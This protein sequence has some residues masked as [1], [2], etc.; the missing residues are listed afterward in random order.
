MVTGELAA[1]GGSLSWA[2]CSIFFTAAVKRLG[3]PALNLV[4]L[5]MAL[6][7]LALA[8][9]LWK[10]DLVPDGATAADGFWLALSAVV[11]LVVGDLFYFASLD[12]VGP[13]IALLLFTL[14]PP[15]AALGELLLFR[16]GL[17]LPGIAGMAVTLSGV[18][19]VVTD[20]KNGTS[21]G[22]PRALL[23]KGVLLGLGA[24][25]CQGAGL[26]LS[27]MGLGTLDGL[28]GTFIR[29]LAAAPLFSLCYLASGRRIGVLKGKGAG[30][31]FALGGAFFGPF[32]GVTLSLVAVKH[33][34]A[35]VAMTLLSTT[36]VTV[37]PYVVFLYGERI[38]ARAVAGA[39]I[40]VAG[41]ALLCL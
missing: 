32:L 11:G 8:L 36:P 9:L 40:A 20:R 21:S 39:L 33:T 41:V 29:M 17:S 24:A 38:S 31:G 34:H 22:R 4:R 26:V 35:G 5:W 7:F 13:R 14:S 27:K 18:V 30:L 19:L 23:W 28:S 10:G 16:R 15:V 25:V 6:A 12:A 3:A 1:L 37:L 2:T